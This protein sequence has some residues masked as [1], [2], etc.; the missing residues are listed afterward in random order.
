MLMAMRLLGHV[1][2]CPPSHNMPGCGTSFS[3][4]TIFSSVVLV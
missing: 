2:V 3:Y 4:I 1:G